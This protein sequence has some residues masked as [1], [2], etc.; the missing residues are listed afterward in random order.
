MSLTTFHRALLVLT[1][2]LGFACTDHFLDYA[3][4]QLRAKPIDCDGQKGS[5]NDCELACEPD[6]CGPPLGMPNLLCDDGIH[7][8]GPGEC[9]DQGGVCGWE[10]LTCPDTVC[11]GLLGLPCGDGQICVDDPADDCDPEQGGSDCIGVCVDE[12]IPCGGF[13]GLECPK[14]LTCVDDPSD[15]CNP[16]KGGADC[17]G[18]C[19]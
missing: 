6:D 11:G 8:S 15:D 7:V 13:A 4:E 12:T 10:I 9:V 18:M 17:I 3:P 5:P 1:C 14:G 19:I 16:A 2:T